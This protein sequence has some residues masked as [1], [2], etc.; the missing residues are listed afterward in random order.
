[1]R[2]SAISSNATK[3][4]TGAARRPAASRKTSTKAP[5]AT[6]DTAWAYLVASS[7]QQSETLANQDRWARET[8]AKN[9]WTISHVEKGISSGQSG[10]RKLTGS[11]IDH[12]RRLPASERPARL[13][14]MRLDRLGRDN[15]IEMC[16]VIGELQQ[17][18]VTIHTRDDGDYT[19]TKAAG[20]IV[21]IMKLILD[22]IEREIRRDRRLQRASQQNG[23]R[24]AA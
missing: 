5:V 9:G 6:S 3:S 17:L 15:P 4:A 7:A 1:M 2:N 10:P 19:M 12:L 8:A 24:G 21:P 18:G 16:A 11:V 13:L 23:T 14:V 22:G 20:T